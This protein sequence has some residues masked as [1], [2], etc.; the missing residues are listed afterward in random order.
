MR[1]RTLLKG[2]LEAFAVVVIVSMLLGQVLGQPILLGYVTTSSMEPT[3][4]A[5]D[6]FVAVPTAVT[7]D[8]EKGDVVVFEASEIQGGGLTTHRVVDRTP[9]GY[10]TKGDANPFTDQDGDEPPVKDRQIR[11]E[12]LQIGGTVVTVPHLGTAITTVRSVVGTVVGP[13]AGGSIGGVFVAVGL[14]LVALAWLT[15]GGER[16]VSRVRSRPNVFDRRL[17]FGL[18]L[19][20]VV[21]PTTAAMV[22]PSGA[23]E[24]G[25]LVA[26][27][28]EDEQLVVEAGGQT[29]VEYVVEN[30]G[31][32]PVV[33]VVEPNSEGV[34]VDERRQYASARGSSTA[35]LTLEGG[36]S[37]GVH[38]RE[39]TER[40]Y[41]AVLP[42]SVLVTLHDIHPLVAMATVDLVTAFLVGSLVVLVAGARNQRIRSA[43]R[44]RPLAARLRRW[45]F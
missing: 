12:A 31:I 17:L 26:E 38:Y 15:D 25:L 34:T 10:V 36:E 22:V 33:A 4:D 19:L 37:T 3:V 21:V 29:S 9:E 30:D 45:L 44:D 5:G 11:A 13:I 14:A 20:V 23:T 2:T 28:P 35:T 42:M 24:Y 32:V 43:T 39:V 6:G 40:R 16:I 1:L 7:G 41:L 8:V 27:E 18:L